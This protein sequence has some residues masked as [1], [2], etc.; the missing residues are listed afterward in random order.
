[1]HQK[2]AARQCD[3]YH[4]CLI[5][6]GLEA[7]PEQCPRFNNLCSGCGE[8][9]QACRQMCPFDAMVPLTEEET[10]RTSAPWFDEPPPLPDV[11][12]EKNAL[13]P[14]LTLAIRGVGGQGNLF[15]GRILTQLAF[16]AG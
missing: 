2:G 10:V 8:Q 3:K 5:C 16:L 6:P 4:A 15:F 9:G 13:P 7:K 14:K 11:S 1:M 12:T